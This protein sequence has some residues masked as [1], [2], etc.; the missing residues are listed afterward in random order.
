M[1]KIIKLQVISPSNVVK[2]MIFNTDYKDE[3]VKRS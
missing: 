3:L 2:R 1:T